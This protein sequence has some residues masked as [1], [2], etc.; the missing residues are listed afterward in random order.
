MSFV[1]KVISH[2][3]NL[4]ENKRTLNSL[5]QEIA[6]NFYPER[7]DFT[8]TRSLG[9]EFA[10]HL[11]TSYPVIARRELGNALSG[12][13]RPTQKEWFKIATNRDE[14]LNGVSKKWLEEKTKVMKRAMYDKDACFVRA[15][16]EGD[17]DFAAFGQCAISLDVNMK[18]NS[19]LYRC[20]HLRDMAWNET[21]D[22]RIG[23]IS[24][25]WKPQCANLLIEMGEK[26]LHKNAIKRAE[27]EPFKTIECRHIVLPI[28]FYRSLFGDKNYNTPYVEL[29]I[30]VEN[31]HIMEETP[32]WTHKYVIPRW[33]TVSGSQYAYSPCT[34]AALP[35]ARLIQAMTL[36]LLEAGEKAANPPVIATQEAVRSDVQLYAG[37]VTW[38]DAEYDERL[39]EA[40]RPLR[41]DSGQIPLGME[42]RQDIKEMISE[43]FY[44]NKINLP[45]VGGDMTAYEIAQRIQEYIRSALPLFEPME[46]DYNGELCEMTF[47]ELMRVGAFGSIHD[48]PPELSGADIQFKFES[49]LHEA[50][51]KQNAQIFVQAKALLAEAAALDPAA[52]SMINASVALRDA[53]RGA[54]TPEKWLR[55]EEEMKAIETQRAQQQQIQQ[56]LST[57][58]QG[59]AA[60]E[61]IGKAGQAIQ[62]IQTAA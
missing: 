54:G 17:H 42:M 58:Q 18:K 57:L 11:T 56:T 4:H 35:D 30:D 21:Y 32:S 45:P 62:G 26:K 3:N 34:V 38:V 5:H 16:K 49:P 44:L 50:N 40:L 39:G 1:E 46:M 33:Q 14:Q 59:G 24:R 9:N 28:D 52:P 22:S 23:V 31:K 55:D 43:A 20:W 25:N 51:D 2:S 13:L 19:L 12:M 47:D 37:G 7:A 61:Q 10:A 48:M 53:L 41:L 8:T 15:T 60:A 6:D 27:K 29:Y 36:T